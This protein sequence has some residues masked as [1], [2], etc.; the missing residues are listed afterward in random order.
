MVVTIESHLQGMR[1]CDTSHTSHRWAHLGTKCWN[2]MGLADRPSCATNLIHNLIMSHVVG[3]G[4]Y[5]CLLGTT[6][7][8]HCSLSMQNAED[9]RQSGAVLSRQMEDS[10]PGRQPLKA[11][12]NH[13]AT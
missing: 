4:K 11:S 6:H 5:R 10:N 8:N 2:C 12:L 3:V 9:N 1:W 7:E 13:L